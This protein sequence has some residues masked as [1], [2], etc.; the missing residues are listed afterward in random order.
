MNGK[1]SHS[2]SLSNLILD[3]KSFDLDTQPKKGKKK[4]MTHV[5]VEPT[6]SAIHGDRAASETPSTRGGS[7]CD[8]DD[9]K[10]LVMLR[11][12]HSRTGSR[13]DNN[14][15]KTRSSTD[16]F[17]DNIV[18]HNS[19]FEQRSAHRRVYGKEKSP[20][21][22]SKVFKQRQNLCQPNERPVSLDVQMDRHPKFNVRR[23]SSNT[24]SLTP[25]PTKSD[26]DRDYN[27]GSISSVDESKDKPYP[28]CFLLMNRNQSSGSAHKAIPPESFRKGAIDEM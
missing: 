6:S 2:V 25:T 15:L 17:K 11:R 8:S 14:G 9:S 21:I 22:E 4:K 1:K 7:I 13:A 16:I 10:D 19:T 5:E 27:R 23:D 20:I 12:K 18:K 28:D 26:S 24:N 3:S